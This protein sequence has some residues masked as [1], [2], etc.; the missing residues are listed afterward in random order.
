MGFQNVL[1]TWVICSFDLGFRHKVPSDML[2]WRLAQK[3]QSCLGGL[4]INS[5]S[6]PVIQQDSF[7]LILS[8]LLY[9]VVWSD[10]KF[11]RQMLCC[12]FHPHL[13]IKSKASAYMSRHLHIKSKTS[14][15][16]IGTCF[17]FYMQMPLDI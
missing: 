4:L 16:T 13:R 9:T 11:Y 2:T 6:L 3:S 8:F 7:Q 17:R 5:I 12:F 14:A 10:Y 1:Q 15:Y